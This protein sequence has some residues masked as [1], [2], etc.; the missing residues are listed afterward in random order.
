MLPRVLRVSCW[1]L[2]LLLAGCTSR[3]ATV[4]GRITLD[5]KP[6]TTGNVSFIPV[7]GGPVA[8]GSIQSDGAYQ[9][10]TG[11]DVGLQPG[12]YVVTVVAAKPVPPSGPDNPE[13]IPE[14]ITPVKYG[15]RETSD[16]KC[17]VK[18]GANTQNFDLKSK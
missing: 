9:V 11:T 10:E 7:N 6:L 4:S 12:D 15:S 8:V 5:D 2:L 13:P 17:A 1:S 14:L 18:P 3:H 16:L